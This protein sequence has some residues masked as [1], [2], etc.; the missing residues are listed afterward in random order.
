MVELIVCFVFEQFILEYYIFFGFDS[1]DLNQ[2][3]VELLE[4]L[5]ENL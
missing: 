3:E 1:V 2:G 5:V 4:V